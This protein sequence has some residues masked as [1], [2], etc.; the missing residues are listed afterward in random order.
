M[1]M[2]DNKLRGQPALVG[3]LQ[4]LVAAGIGLI[5]PQTGS[6]T[7]TLVTSGTGDKVVSNF[8]PSWIVA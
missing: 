7:T 3:H 5:D 4:T 2:I 6:V 8:E 1:P